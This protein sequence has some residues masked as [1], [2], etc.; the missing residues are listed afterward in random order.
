M[1]LIV[2]GDILLFRAC[3]AVEKD[4][5]FGDTHVLYSKFE[6]AKCVLE[7]MVHELQEQ[8]NT[9]EVIFSLS[10]SKNW[11]RNIFKEY[12][13]NRKGSRKPLCYSDLQEYA[14]Q[15]WESMRFLGIEADDIMGIYADREGY[16]I[17]SLDKD[18]K[19]CPGHHLVDDEIIYISKQQGDRFHMYQTLVG[20]PTDNYKGCPGVGDAG[21]EDFLTQPFEYYEE[22]STLKSGPNK[23]QQRVTWK[24]KPTNNIWRGIV[25]HFEKH[26]LTEAD[27]LVQARVARIL[28]DGEYDF[29]KEEV[30]LWNP[31]N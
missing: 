27:A 28:Q 3:A 5:S 29:E 1:K 11:R 31:I 9:D 20:D 2:D 18:L 22:W 15:H 21:A 4:V 16:A 10:D 12:K 6:D 23:G 30:K 24:K 8:A 19:Q 7:D 13:A 26:G 17:W 25:S 14:I